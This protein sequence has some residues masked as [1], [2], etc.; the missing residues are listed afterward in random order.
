MLTCSPRGVLRGDHRFAAFGLNQVTE[1]FVRLSSGLCAVALG[2]G[3]SGALA[4]YAIG[5][6]AAFLLGLAQIRDLWRRPRDPIDTARI[7]AFSLP[8]LGVHFYS[9]FVVNVDVLVAKWCLSETEAGTYGAASTLARF[10]SAGVTPILFVLFSHVA[11]RHA[12]GR[13]VR[14]LALRVGSTLSAGLLAGVVLLWLASGRS[15]GSPS[16]AISPAASR[17]CASCG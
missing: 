10:L 8:L 11:S 3:A 16:A 2:A 4:G 15:C 12:Q 17:F 7:Y 14:R 9:V 13:N 5:T 6:G 1:S